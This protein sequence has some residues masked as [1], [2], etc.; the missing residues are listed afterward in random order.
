MSAE[1]FHD[2]QAFLRVWPAPAKLNLFL[3]VTG[4]RADGY[5][6]LQTLFR[7]IDLEDRLAFSL[8]EDGEVRVESDLPG[9]SLE[10]HL[11]FRAARLLQEVTGV[12]RGV[13]IRLTK[14]L[15]LG[16]GLGG[17]SSD[18]ATTLLALNALW[19]TGL[20]RSRLREIALPLGADVPFFLFGENAFAEGVGER[21]RAVSLPERWYFL[22]FPPV[23]VP[24]ASIFR[25]PELP[26][27]T[28]PVRAEDW[29][30][31]FGRNDLEAAV[32]ARYPP[33]A[34][35]LRWLGETARALEAEGCGNIICR[36]SGSGATVFAECAEELTARAF[37]AR[38]PGDWRGGVAR[39]LTRHPLFSL[40]S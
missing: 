30:P 15:P 26:R 23:C 6:F 35:A 38:L 25:A 7:L 2:D 40:A 29:F 1:I 37:L 32:V 20:S 11:C 21:L 16:G 8:R 24:T 14:N 10:D 22:V 31:G 36:M 27:R 4:R 34:E 12:R 33:V 19:Q 18:A 13:S 39:G 17:G 9:V 5:H 3:H 28:P